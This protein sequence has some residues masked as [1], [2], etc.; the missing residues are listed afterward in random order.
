MPITREQAAEQVDTTAVAVS[1]ARL[2]T[3]WA[4]AAAR[5]R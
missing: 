3:Q 4:L 5:F 2:I 1:K